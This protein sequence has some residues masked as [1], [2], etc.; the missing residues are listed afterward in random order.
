MF[1]LVFKINQRLKLIFII[2]KYK[3]LKAKNGI[4]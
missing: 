4:F 2:K 3:F 1:N